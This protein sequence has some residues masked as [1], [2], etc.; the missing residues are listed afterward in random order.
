ML[1][2]R[3]GC[4]SAATCLGAPREGRETVGD[5]GPRA[6]WGMSVQAL[7]HHREATQVYVGPF[8]RFSTAVNAVS[9]KAAK[10]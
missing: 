7:K 4:R 2:L 8:A 10:L 6:G 5:R 3:R 1:L 9:G